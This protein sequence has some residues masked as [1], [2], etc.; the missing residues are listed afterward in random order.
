MSILKLNRFVLI[1]P[2]RLLSHNY[3][4]LH[5]N[6]DIIVDDVKKVVDFNN[7]LL[8]KVDTKSNFDSKVFANLEELLGSLKGS[9]SKLEV[10]PSSSISQESFSKFLS[11]FETNLKAEVAP[12]L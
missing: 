9:L 3:S 6:I 7:S 11:T 12:L 8:N 10:S 4:N 2:R 5:T 1:C